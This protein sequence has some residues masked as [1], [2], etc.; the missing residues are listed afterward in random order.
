MTTPT[1]EELGL[2]GADTAR[3]AE[4][5]LTVGRRLRAW[6]AVHR[7]SI[8]L[9]GTLLM[10]VAVVHGWGVAHAPSLNDDEGTYMSQ[11]WAFQHEHRLSVYTYWYDHPPLGW[12]QIALFTFVTGPVTS[13]MHAV[14]AGRI[15]MVGLAVVSAALLYVLARRTGMGRPYAALAVLLFGLSPLA[16]D[17][18]RMVFLD[19]IAVPWMLAA[20]VLAASPRRSLWAAA[21][22]GACFAASV[23]SKETFLLFAPGLVLLLWTRSHPKTRA[24]CVT[25]LVATFTL[26]VISYPLYAVLK[27]ELLPGPHHVSLWQ[28]ITFQL[29]SRQGSG[30]VFA[31]GSNAHHTVTGWLQLDPWLLAIGLAAAVCCLPS[32]RYRPFSV[33]LAVSIGVG[34]HGGYLPGP[35]VIGL[36]PFAALCVAAVF[37]MLAGPGRT[38]SGRPW[39]RDQALRPAVSGLLAAGLVA[40]LAVA[41]TP[42]DRS[43][44][45]G[46]ATTPVFDAEAWMEAHISPDQRII[47]D[48][49]LWN[50]LIEHGFRRDLG[51]VW[52]QKLDFTENLDPSVARALPGGWRD[53]AYIVSTPALRSSLAVSPSG[54]GPVR[55]AL[56]RSV[57]VA[58][59]G[60]GAALVQVR[61]IVGAGPRATLPPRHSSGTGRVPA[62]ERSVPQRKETKGR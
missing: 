38:L 40:G 52:F 59:F 33:A 37:T 34:L 55:Q 17:F 28:A 44:M 30:S 41:W 47:V 36:L 39:K 29:W 10:V 21:G 56:A 14:V 8:M 31:A 20:M 25:G 62:T 5:E 12:M 24:F 18:Q 6:A 49:T 19:N 32:R 54:F 9:L 13:S 11:A 53:F 16:V 15:F 35:F 45:H 51:V 61:R 60:R 26:L 57:V 48:N 4:A 3:R 46:D 43:L 23:L 1:L 50:D 42:G 7:R 27:G 2:V 22:S 58:S